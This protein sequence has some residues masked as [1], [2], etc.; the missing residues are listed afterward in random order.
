LAEEREALR[1]HITSAIV[2]CKWLIDILFA[3]FF[4]GRIR[5]AAE[6]KANGFTLGIRHAQWLFG[7][8]RPLFVCVDQNQNAGYTSKQTNKSKIEIQRKKQKT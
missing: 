6:K 5:N 7:W 8:H 2:I 4:P 3:S 1:D